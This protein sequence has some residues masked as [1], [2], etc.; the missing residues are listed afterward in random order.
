MA[1]VDP[2]PGEFL[3][4]AEGL[5]PGTP[6]VML[7][8]LRFRE[9]A[10]YDGEPGDCSGREAYLDRYGPASFEHVTAV[11]GEL[12]F[13][14]AAH[15]ALIGPSDEAWDMVLLVRYPSIEAFVAMATGPAYLEIARHRTAALADSRLVPVVEG[16]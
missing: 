16:L 11:G 15:A 2:D 14:G 1:T 5:P 3:A 13:A 8:L 7:N 12:V 9:V 10:E 4:A 6:L